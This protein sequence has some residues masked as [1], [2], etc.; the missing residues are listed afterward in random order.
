LADV[1]GKGMPAALMV[2][3]LQ[4]RVQPLFE[5]LPIAPGTLATAMDRLNRL[6]TANCPLGRFI[7]CFAC[8][9]DGQT[10]SVQ[11]SCAGHNPPLIIRA[12]GPFEILDGGGPILGVFEDITYEQQQAELSSGDLLAIYSDGVTECCSP[13]EEEFDV[14]R[15]ANVLAVN[16]RESAEDITRAVAKA[17][18]EWTCGAPPTDDIT[19][20]IAKKL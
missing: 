5:N 3:A 16:R 1:S 10:G 19:I 12:K 11:W 20:V 7:T 9:A 4:A 2:M 13:S 17:V 14:E 18:A 15:L 6:T 8:V